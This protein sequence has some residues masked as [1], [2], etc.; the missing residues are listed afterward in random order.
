MRCS[1]ADSSQQLA[2]APWHE[3]CSALKL[4]YLQ[5]MPTA[6]ATPSHYQQQTQV[7]AAHPRQHLQPTHLP[8]LQWISSERVLSGPPL[9]LRLCQPSQQCTPLICVASGG[10]HY[11]VH[12]ELVG[13]AAPEGGVVPAGFLLHLCQQLGC[14]CCTGVGLRSASMALC[15]RSILSSS[16]FRQSRSVSKPAG[17]SAH[18][19]FADGL[20]YFLHS[21]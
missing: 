10:G 1:S 21:S 18:A 13:D 3:C 12:E 9:C 15:T 7:H 17:Q 11:R 14:A 2:T 8:W 19:F 6:A 4:Q 5:S 20:E 16:C